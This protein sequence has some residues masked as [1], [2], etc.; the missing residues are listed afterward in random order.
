MGAQAETMSKPAPCRDLL[1]ELK[2][3]GE[4]PI[5]VEQLAARVEKVLALHREGQSFGRH[6]CLNCGADWPCPTVCLLNGEKP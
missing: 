1:L 3:W 6:Y 4:V 2:A 5:E